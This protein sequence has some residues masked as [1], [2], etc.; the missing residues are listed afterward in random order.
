MND[1][2]SWQVSCCKSRAPFRTPRSE[3]FPSRALRWVKV[4]Y[5]NLALRP[6]VDL[7]FMVL[8]RDVPRARAVLAEQGFVGGPDERVLP[9]FLHYTNEL[10]LIRER[11]GRLVEVQWAMAPRYFSIPLSSSTLFERLE[12]I[13]FGGRRIPSFSYEDELLMLLVHGKHLWERLI[14]I[15]NVAELIKAAP[16][17]DWDRILEPSRDARI[18][19]LTLV[20]LRLAKQLQADVPIPGQILG[21]MHSDPMVEVIARRVWFRLLSRDPS[22]SDPPLQPLH[23]LMRE[24]IRDAAAHCWRLATTPTWGDWEWLTLPDKDHGHTCHCGPCASASSTPSACWRRPRN[25]LRCCAAIRRLGRRLPLLPFERRAY[26][27]GEV[28]HECL[29]RIRPLRLGSETWNA[30]ACLSTAW[31]S[32]ALRDQRGEDEHPALS[33]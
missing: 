30:T 17:L 4:S 25:S 32:A 5:G 6:S 15:S 1:R 10:A 28:T 22:S 14:W 19:R 26:H 24:D 2:S 9:S 27:A 8:R 31:T 3:P 7:D 12:T 21:A 16:G 20:G 18:L 29:S 13:E 23:L 33:E 11:D